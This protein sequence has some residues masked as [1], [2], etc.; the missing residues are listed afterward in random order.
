[1]SKESRATGVDV[2]GDVLWGTHICQFYQ[3]KEDLIEILVPYFK[4]GLED[5]ESCLWVTSEPLGVE[6]ARAAL[7][8]AFRNLDDYIKKGQIEIVHY[9]EWYTKD[10]KFSDN[11]AWQYLLEKENLAIERGFDGLRVS[12]NV[13]WLEHRDWENLIGY[14]SLVDNIIEGHRIVAV[15]SYLL[16]KWGTAE[17]TDIITNHRFVLI[18]RAGQWQIIVNNRRSIFFRLRN[19]GLSYAEIGRKLGLS[20]ERVRQIMTSKRTKTKRSSSLFPSDLLSIGEAAKYLGVHTNTLRNWS[21]NKIVRT[22]H[23][24]RRLDRRF[25]LQD[26]DDLIK[27]KF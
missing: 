8:Q 2:L 11:E 19:S 13:S 25:K 22:Y 7:D 6:E 27:K 23:F 1:M 15:C 17:L 9:S 4:S 26:L 16:D 21:N 24:G 5:N 18:R 14:E 10:G 12:G 20:R 3:T